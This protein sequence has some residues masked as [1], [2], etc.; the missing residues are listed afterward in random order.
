[1]AKRLLITAFTFFILVGSAT[2]QKFQLSN[3]KVGLKG[4]IT[5]SDFTKNVGFFDQNSPNYRNSPYAAYEEYFRIGALAGITLDYEFSKAFT[6]GTE[7]LH[8]GRGGAY[9][10]ENSS[11]AIITNNG[12]EKAYNYYQYRINYLE[13]PLLAQ[14]NLSS[15][16]TSSIALIVYGG[17]APGFP[18]TEKITYTNYERSG[19]IDAKQT[20]QSEDLYNVRGFNLSPTFGFKIRGN[21][22]DGPNRVYLDFRFARTV[23]PVF[24]IEADGNGNNFKT[25]M[26]TASFAVGARLNRN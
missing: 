10:V 7:L 13:L 20:S 16:A 8:N 24:T 15:K 4:G 12:A 23:L 26:W 11:V 19:V 9:R 18:T 2:A 25:G 3:F 6:V 21:D 17:V 1:M 5:L 22:A 14:Y